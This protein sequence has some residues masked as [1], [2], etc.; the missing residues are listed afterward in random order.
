M[1]VLRHIGPLSCK[2]VSR[3]DEEDIAAPIDL[4]KKHVPIEV[5]HRRS[6]NHN[7]AAPYIS[8]VP[9]VAHA[10]SRNLNILR[11]TEQNN[12]RLCAISASASAPNGDVRWRE[13]SL[14]QPND[15]DNNS[16]S[17]PDSGLQRDS[18]GE[19]DEQAG[20]SATDR[21]SVV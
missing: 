7:K 2:I 20:H 5:P 21:K 4:S 9:S 10:Q 8:I 13:V 18:P 11:N 6:S 3:E 16:Y 19:D 15:E 1:M 17:S 12:N 14:V